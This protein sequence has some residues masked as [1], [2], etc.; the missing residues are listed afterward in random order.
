MS[1]LTTDDRERIAADIVVSCSGRWTD[2]VM[3]LAGAEISMAPTLGMLVTTSKVASAQRSLVHAPGVNLRPDGGSRFLLAS[4]EIDALLRDDLPQESLNGFAEE[5]L[6]RAQSVLPSL[7]GSS[8]ESIVIGVRS[9]PADGF[10]AV[11]PV[12]GTEGMYVVATHSGI[13]MG[14][15]LGR[16]AAQ[17]ILGGA[18]DVRLETFRPDRFL[19]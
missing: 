2:R 4:Y 14:P 7:S 3:A 15:L 6:D 9:I 1:G 11:G 19:V 17:E 18:P 13:T 5:I 12:P 8:V 10:P 16:L